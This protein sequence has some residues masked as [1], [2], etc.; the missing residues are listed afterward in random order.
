LKTV[1]NSINYDCLLTKPHVALSAFPD[2]ME[3]EPYLRE[4]VKQINFSAF[5]ILKIIGEGAFSQVAVVRR[6]DTGVIYA[7]K[8]L[9]KKMFFDKNKE[10]YILREKEILAAI[11]HPHLVVSSNQG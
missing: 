8:I 2:F 7:M 1:E 4:P 9:K 5:K 11:D 10:N 6:K 3:L